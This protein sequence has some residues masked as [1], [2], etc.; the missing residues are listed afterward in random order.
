M[1]VASDTVNIGGEEKAA[2]RSIKDT[3]GKGWGRWM[4]QREHIVKL[5]Q[6]KYTI[7]SPRTRRR[8]FWVGLWLGGGC[9]Y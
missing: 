4:R 8:Y 1:K 9:N 5:F 2:M 6:P 7:G 3:A